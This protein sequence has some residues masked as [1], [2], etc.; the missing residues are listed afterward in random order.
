MAR[1]PTVSIVRCDA[2]ADDHKVMD[3]VD[4][5][6]DLLGGT[7]ETFRGLGSVFVKTN[8]GLKE[9]KLHAGRQVALTEV[10]VLRA[11]VRALRQHTDAEILV[12]DTTTEGGTT[13]ELYAA[14]GYREA[15]AEYDVRLIDINDGPLV[16]AKVPGGGLMFDRYWISKTVMDADAVVSVQKMKAHMATGTTLTMKNL[17]GITPLSVYG[18]PRRYLHA[19]VRLPHTIA[20]M[21][22]LFK[23]R[24]CVIDGLVAMNHKEWY[25]PALKTDV[26]VAGDNTVATDVVGTHLMGFD[27]VGEHPEP[28]Y[29]FDR[30][31]LRLAADAGLGPLQLADIN[32][33]GDRLQKVGDF[34]VH[35]NISPADNAQVHRTLAE[36]VTH[37][38]QERDNYVDR[39][40]GQYIG[41]SGGQVMFQGTD[42]Q[43]LKS[44]RQIAIEQ[45]RANQG[46]FL[47]FVEPQAQDPEHLSVYDTYGAEAA[48]G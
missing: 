23:P 38:T 1:K 19:H 22:L 33:T 17:F 26:I 13:E 18:A 47:K 24:L 46:L 25:G 45:G 42:L 34:E 30:N 9:I 4:R 37:Y 10:C 2:R 16:E 41:L 32:V 27:P 5:A 8:I 20:D 14:M 6:L 29:V 11:V 39:F 3:A 12:G 28:P 43:H 40:A 36:Q 7:M 48:G 15:L 35:A 21:G 31:P 44:R